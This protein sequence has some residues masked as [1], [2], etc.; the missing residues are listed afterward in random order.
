MKKI[1][2]EVQA[3]LT[4]FQ[5]QPNPS[6]SPAIQSYFRFY[7]LDFTDIG[8]QLGFFQ[9]GEYRL[10][11]HIFSPKAPSATVI[12][13]HGYYDHT[14][15]WKHVIKTLLHN[16]YR[17]AIFEQPGHGLSSGER[18]TI[19]DFSHYTQ[20]LADFLR[21][22]RS[23]YIG[24]YHILAH[25]MGSTV[26]ID[27]LFRHGKKDID[28]IILLAPLVRTVNWHQA[29]V[30]NIL[31]G[32]II[33]S[34]P[35]KFR[36]NSMDSTY[37]TFTKRDPLHS[38]WVPLQWFRAL[39]QWQR[40]AT[41]HPPQLIDLKVIQGNIDDTVDWRYNIPWLKRKFPQTEVIE[42]VMGKHQLIN[43]DARLRK[44]ALSWI[45]YFLADP[46][47]SVD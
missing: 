20:A 41:E 23:H 10:A 26:I 37:L 1:L 36:N 5:F 44:Q 7:E 9:S 30:A 6:Y 29:K 33:K 46:D 11:A 31:F 3:S 32:K 43:E 16:N 15:T 22:I 25:S 13:L 19:A 35:R 21:I 28:T 2:K 8:H 14:G 39:I 40:L 12:I 45:V 24:P 38:K 18:A 17:V 4:P 27:F 34:V 47:P 42:I